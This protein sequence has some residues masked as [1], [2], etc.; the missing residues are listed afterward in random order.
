MFDLMI[1]KAIVRLIG[2]SS[3]SFRYIPMKNW[4]MPLQYGL[5][6]EDTSSF[7]C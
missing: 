6:G 2:F 7:Q 4:G 1:W 5:K 3:P